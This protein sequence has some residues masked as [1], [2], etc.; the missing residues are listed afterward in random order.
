MSRSIRLG[1]AVV[2]LALSLPVAA[3]ERWL[4]LHVEERGS[5]GTRV[6]VQLPFSA[7]RAALP[8]LR[9]NGLDRGKLR[10][11]TGA[12]DPG[13]LARARESLREAMEGR[14]VEIGDADRPLR[15]ERRGDWLVITGG[16]SGPDRVRLQVPVEIAREVLDALPDSIDLLAIV[17]S[18]G[19][20]GDVEIARVDTDDTSVRIW[21][22]A[23]A[24]TD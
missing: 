11:E 14:T 1:S 20:D 6:R 7:I 16:E 23:T 8:H 15:L 12:V 10:L 9:A 5:D 21:L 18:I 22:D 19:E 4:H 13:N 17:D 3:S 2:A 24:S